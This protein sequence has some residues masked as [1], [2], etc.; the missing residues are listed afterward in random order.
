MK[1]QP[2]KFLTLMLRL[3]KDML[4]L[5]M[6]QQ[7]KYMNFFVGSKQKAHGLYMAGMHSMSYL[8]VK[9]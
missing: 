9:I 8:P 7:Q 5:P 2:V 1:K 4:G 3:M 6:Q